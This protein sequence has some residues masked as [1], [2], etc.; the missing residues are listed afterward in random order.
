[1]NKL[2]K[3]AA[4]PT[5]VLIVLASQQAFATNGLAPTGLG[6]SHK[7]MGGAAVGNPMNTMS[8]ATNPAAG[9]FIADGFDVG[10][11]LF[12]PN[13]TTTISGTSG[14]FADGT[15]V[16][17]EDS[18]F[19]IPEGGYKKTMGDY[20]IGVTVYGNGGMNTNYK[21]E[22]SPYE[23]FCKANLGHSCGN[24]GIDFQQLFISPTFA[25]KIGE[26]HSIGISANLV[27]QKI[28][29]DGIDV[30]GGPGGFSSDSTS[31]TGNGYDSSTGIGATVGW[32]AKASDDVT[33]G[34][35]YRFKTKMG[36]F[37]KYKG[38]FPDQGR[39]DVPAA[40]TIGL[41]WKATP[42]TT[43]A[44]DVQRIYY[45][46]VGAIGSST[47]L[48]PGSLGTSD[49]PGFNWTDQD[50]IKIG[51][52]HQLNSKLALMGGYNHGDSPVQA[53]STLFNALAPAVVE[54]HLS[55]GGEW[56]LN[57]KSKIT[58]TYVHTFSNELKGAGSLAN[59]GI[60][61]EADLKMDQDAIGV[62]YSR[63]F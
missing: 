62:G 5:A 16:G 51:V 24:T 41:G 44:A 27:Y 42:K 9:S 50:V 43:V 22:N 15:F 45:G 61:G 47:P 3:K 10:L 55:V 17:D 6:Q 34:A 21:A 25:A 58:A 11:E 2:F 26:N 23:A 37:D 39:M 7:A 18:V 4:L 48:T 1:M 59:L 28:K 14:G 13:R 31:L 56:K 60:A 53:Q 40:L 12:K 57:D 29:V 63:T 54:D 33:V 30:F 32:Q 36:K 19:L 49:G 38:L 52:K 8:M 35:S 46:D 20:A